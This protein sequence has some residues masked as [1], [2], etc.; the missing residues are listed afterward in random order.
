MLTRRVAVTLRL[1]R[2]SRD[3]AAMDRPLAAAI[4]LV[5]GASGSQKVAFAG[6]RRMEHFAARQFGFASRLLVASPTIA[7]E[8]DWELNPTAV[9]PSIVS[10]ATLTPYWWR[11][12][13][14]GGSFRASPESRTI[15][16]RGCPHCAA[17]AAAANV[18]ANA[19]VNSSADDASAMRSASSSRR[20]QPA[21]AA[22]KRRR[23]SAR[24]A[25]A[26]AAAAPLPGELNP[27]MRPI[28][29]GKALMNN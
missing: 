27:K 15:R 20:R 25:D 16:G 13:A 9:F 8:W 18:A 21:A 24:A 17:T 29:S 12:R 5:S 14:C 11:C 7:A 2:F 28:A 6:C 3:A 23:D 1:P 4:A 22:A 10:T 26:N 19:A